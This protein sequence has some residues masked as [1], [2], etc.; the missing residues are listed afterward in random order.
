MPTPT[1]IKEVRE[2]EG[3]SRKDFAIEL[4]VPY[5]TLTNYEN[6]T[7]E[8]PYD[9]LLKIA[10]IFGT[11]VDYLLCRSNDPEWPSEIGRGLFGETELERCVDAL[12][13]N[14]G[15]VYYSS[16]AGNHRL[17]MVAGD[18]ESVSIT[19]D[20]W[21]QLVSNIVSYTTYTTKTLYD[22]A[23]EREKDLKG[24]E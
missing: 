5:S 11:T 10:H 12:I 17:D 16:A 21:K 9:F 19:E 24:G 3:Y 1:R 22:K 23:R 18:G 2:R 8:P 4:G 6:G 7:R 20:E 13:E 15:V 14:I